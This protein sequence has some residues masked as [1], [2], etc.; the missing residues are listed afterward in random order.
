MHINPFS[1]ATVTRKCY[2]SYYFAKFLQSIILTQVFGVCLSVC[3]CV[4][5]CVCVCVRQ[6][7]F[8]IDFLL[9]TTHIP[10]VKLLLPSQPKHPH[11]IFPMEGRSNN[12]ILHCILTYTLTIFCC[13]LF[14]FSIV[15]MIKHL[16]K[17]FINYS[18][19]IAFINGDK[20]VLT[21]LH[22]TF[23]IMHF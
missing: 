18:V 10:T 4:C 1:K 9:E 21:P 3:V 5:L 23:Y 13:L 22:S 6:L 8:P 11:Y 12:L 19:P 16:Q 15:S 20:W 7:F 17:M 14:C 2:T